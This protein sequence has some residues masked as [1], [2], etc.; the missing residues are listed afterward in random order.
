MSKATTLLTKLGG[1]KKRWLLK[2]IKLP[3]IK[4][5][6]FH[7]KTWWT[8]NL[9]ILFPGLF[10]IIAQS[11]LGSAIP[12]HWSYVEIV[13]KQVICEFLH[14]RILSSTKK[15]NKKAHQPNLPVMGLSS[16]LRYLPADNRVWWPKKCIMQANSI[17]PNNGWN[18]WPNFL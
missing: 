7:C 9:F 12:F 1:S 10:E 16:A 17:K 8:D 15:S 5:T 18:Y 13:R 4:H 2:K 14:L 6:V 11:A 3:W